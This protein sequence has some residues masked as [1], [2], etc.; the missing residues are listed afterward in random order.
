LDASLRDLDTA[1]RHY[2][3]AAEIFLAP[4]TERIQRLASL[5]WVLT[6][7]LSLRAVLGPELDADLWTTAKASAEM[8]LRRCGGSE[9]VWP[10]GSP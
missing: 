10:L 1:A 8:T 4:G 5:H 6:H 9:R 2:W 7:W 3:R